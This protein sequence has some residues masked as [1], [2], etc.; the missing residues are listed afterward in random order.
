MDSPVASRVLVCPRSTTCSGWRTW[1]HSWP[2]QGVLCFTAHPPGFGSLWERQRMVSICPPHVPHPSLSCFVDVGFL[3]SLVIWDID[4]LKGPVLGD[5]ALEVLSYLVQHLL[6]DLRWCLDG[7]LLGLL[8]LAGAGCSVGLAWCSFPHGLFFLRF[9]LGFSSCCFSSGC[10]ASCAI[11]PPFWNK[12][13][14]V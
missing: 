4:D 9:F 13:H 1:F 12:L 8:G 11:C 5:M 7:E 2:W 14:F 10:L 6:G 3:F